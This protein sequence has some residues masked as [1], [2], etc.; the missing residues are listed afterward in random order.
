MAPPYDRTSHKVEVL[1]GSMLADMIGAGIHEV[2][3]YHHQA[4]KIPADCV[5]IMAV[6]EDG[7][8]EAVSVKNKKFIMGVQ[9]HPE[10]SYEVNDESVKMVQAFV[11][12]CKRICNK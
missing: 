7:L 8:V 5:D 4:V 11:D 6:S 1:D 3:S 10:F 12:A 2:N 9:W